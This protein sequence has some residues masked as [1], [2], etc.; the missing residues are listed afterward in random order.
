MQAV[1]SCV[2]GKTAWERRSPINSKSYCFKLKAKR[3][4]LNPPSLLIFH[5]KSHRQNSSCG[6]LKLDPE[7]KNIV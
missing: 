7:A 3:C 2:D 6:L 5:L 4:K 1:E